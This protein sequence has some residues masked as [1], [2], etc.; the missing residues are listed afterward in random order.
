MGK[1]L[2]DTAPKTGINAA[3]FALKKIVNKTAEATGELI[4]K[5]IARRLVKT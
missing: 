4:G 5:E 3:E 1:E 2:I